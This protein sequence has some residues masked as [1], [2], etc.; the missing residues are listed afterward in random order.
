MAGVNSDFRDRISISVWVVT[1]TLAAGGFLSLPQ[2][3]ASLVVGG[4]SFT[5]P[6]EAASVIPVLLAVLA[7]SG[8]EAVARAHPLARQGRLSLTMRYWALPIAL[9]LIAVVLL[10]LAP[11][12]LYRAAGLLIF[13]V[14]LSSV[15]TALYFS[16]DQA[17]AGYRRARA[18]LNLICYAITLLLFLLIPATWDSLPRSLT[19]GGV[20]LLLTLELLR[21]AGQRPA[22]VT[23]YALVVS[24]VLAEVAWALSYSGLSTLSAG[25]LLLLLFYLL[26]GLAWQS[27]L[28]RLSRR[29]ALEFAA[30]GLA[31][32]ALILAFAP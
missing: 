18:G 9:T 29:V 13:A 2:R 30:V 26:V 22:T 23:L 15:L 17:A 27:L 24:A 5:L 10:P 20:A 28:G 12:I 21:G 25:L 32:L 11:S 31:G 19:L 14:I 7:G 16:L 8:A 4:G 6:V 3:G 1:M